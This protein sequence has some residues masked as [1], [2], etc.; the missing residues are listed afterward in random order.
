MLRNDVGIVALLLMIAI[1]Y[2]PLGKSV[3]GPF[4][5]GTPSILKCGA[6]QTS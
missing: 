6:E 4:E 2:L 3:M 5:C 1:L